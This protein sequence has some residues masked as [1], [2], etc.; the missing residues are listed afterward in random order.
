VSLVLDPKTIR[1]GSMT[2][3]RCVRPRRKDLQPLT[4]DACVFEGCSLYL[5]RPNDSV[6]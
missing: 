6:P 1:T 5:T 3:A 2:Q 4:R